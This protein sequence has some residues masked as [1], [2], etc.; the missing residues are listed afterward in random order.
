MVR[1]GKASFWFICLCFYT[2]KK[3]TTS[4]NFDMRHTVWCCMCLGDGSQTWTPYL[5]GEFYGLLTHKIFNQVALVEKYHI[6]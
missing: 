6:L 5:S 2:Y 3:S 1:G 4:I